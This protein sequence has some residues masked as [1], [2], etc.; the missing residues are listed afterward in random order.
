VVPQDIEKEMR[1]PPRGWGGVLWRRRRRRTGGARAGSEPRSAH[2]RC[3]RSRTTL[4]ALNLYSEIPDA[5]DDEARA[6]TAAFAQQ[7][8]DR[9]G[10]RA[11]LLGAKELSDQLQKAMESRAAIEQAKGILI[12]Q[13]H[14]SPDEAFNMLVRTSRR[15]S[16]KLR[17][18]A[19]EIVARAQNPNG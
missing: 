8:G 18:I 17:D 1:T 19:A 11:R 5:F 13:R 10:Q 2:R 3:R 4:G 15:E 16:R 14:V 9:D 12:G 7:G 6:S